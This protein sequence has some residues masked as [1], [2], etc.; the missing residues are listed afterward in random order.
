MTPFLVNCSAEAIAQFAKQA[1]NP[2]VVDQS[3]WLPDAGEAIHSGKMD[4]PTYTIILCGD[5][6]TNLVVAKDGANCLFS[7][8]LG[9][10]MATFYFFKTPVADIMRQVRKGRLAFKVKRVMGPVQGG[11]GEWYRPLASELV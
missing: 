2:T 8:E 4:K 7:Y 9:G 11:A 10:T 1:A 5:A 6:L 3:G